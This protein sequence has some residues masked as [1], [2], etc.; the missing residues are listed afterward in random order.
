M[1]RP[2]KPLQAL[3]RRT[4]LIDRQVMDLTMDNMRL[5]GQTAL[6]SGGSTELAGAVAFALALAGVRVCLC[7]RQ[8]DLLEISAGRIRAV[9]G[10]CLTVVS[11]LD[12]LEAAQAVL[13]EALGVYDRLDLLILVSPFWGGGMIHSH[14][15]QT[16]DLVMSANLREPFILSRVVLPV[17]REQRG[18]QIMAIGSDSGLGFYQ[19]DGAYNVAMHGLNNLM[20]LIRL[21]NSDFGIRTH[22]LSPGLTLTDAF[23]MEGKPNLTTEDVCEW[24][25][26]LLTR[27]PHLRGNSPILI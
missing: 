1:L 21:E 19:Q 26:F 4:D 27:P 11:E 9:G 6:I 20:E 15:L 17:F 10:Q 13:D 8:A 7:G 22:T 24:V 12:S 14:K 2:Y 3:T 18:G 23:D 5:D 25:L 16:W